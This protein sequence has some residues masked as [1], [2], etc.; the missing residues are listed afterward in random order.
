MCDAIVSLISEDI[1]LDEFEELIPLDGWDLENYIISRKITIEGEQ[2]LQRLIG[3]NW[4][5]KFYNKWLKFRG[6]C[7]A[8][9]YPFLA[10]TIA[11]FA[12]NIFVAK[13]G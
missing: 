1:S 4:K 3:T 2:D 5:T 11:L 8:I 6:T 9:R 12:L 7:Y 10:I 13:N